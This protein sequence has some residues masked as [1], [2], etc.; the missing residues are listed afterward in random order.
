MK[1]QGDIVEDQV[2]IF[3]FDEAIQKHVCVFYDY[4][5]IGGFK[6]YLLDERSYSDTDSFMR[7]QV[8]QSSNDL[9]QSMMMQNK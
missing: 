4:E 5:G 3:V 7:K 1:P 6:V 2:A 9:N 8:V